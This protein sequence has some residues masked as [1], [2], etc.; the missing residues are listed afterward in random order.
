MSSGILRMILSTACRKPQTT[1][2][3][4]GDVHIKPQASLITSVAS[5]CADFERSIAL[6]TVS[7]LGRQLK[8]ISG[9][10]Q[11][12]AALQPASGES[13]FDA[14]HASGLTQLVGRVEELELLMLHCF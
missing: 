9:P 4:Y 8:G 1:S 7:I 2:K 11:A 3:A 12:W 10:V 6:G 14:P 5:A 13:R